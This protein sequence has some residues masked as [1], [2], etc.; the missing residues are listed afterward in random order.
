MSSSK[1]APEEGYYVVVNSEE[2]YSIWPEAREV[3][4]GWSISGT[5]GPKSEC[6]SY[7]ETTWT[8]MRPRS[9][10]ERMDSATTET[11]KSDATEPAAQNRESLIERL[12]K[13]GHPIVVAGFAGQDKAHFREEINNGHIRV[14]F[15]ETSG[16]TELALRFDPKAIEWSDANLDADKGYLKL[17]SELKLDGSPVKCA[18]EIDLATLKGNGHLEAIPQA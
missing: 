9:L 7:I 11:P 1:A 3:P 13:G 8:D 16:G 12:S 18:V 4:L 2:Q 6:L 15:T 17:T 14:L 5:S 10:R